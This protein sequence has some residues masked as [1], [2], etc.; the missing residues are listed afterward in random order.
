MA[1]DPSAAESLAFAFS[2]ALRAITD[3][4]LEHRIDHLLDYLGLNGHAERS[5]LAFDV[6]RAMPPL[7]ELTDW[8]QGIII[9]RWLAHRVLPYPCFLVS[10]SYLAA[11]AGVQVDSLV[12]SVSD[13]PTN[14]FSEA[15]YRGAL[16]KLVGLRLWRSEVERI[17]GLQLGPASLDPSAVRLMLSELEGTDLQPIHSASGLYVETVDDTGAYG[18]HVHS[19]DDV[20]TVRIDD[21]PDYADLAYTAG[22]GE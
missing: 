11:R 18:H 21:W 14:P 3:S 9:V 20:V 10:S 1:A 12:H 13:L 2:Q 17:L 8:T 19:M 4:A 22:N 6:E 16:D 7:Q 5:S 15:I